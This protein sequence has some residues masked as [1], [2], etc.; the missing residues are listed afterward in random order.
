MNSITEIQRAT[1][2][3]YGLTRDELLGRDRRRR[4]SR[5]RQVA[6]ALS[7]ELTNHSYLRIARNFGRDHSTV[8]HAI[9]K[10]AERAGR[11]ELRKMNAVRAKLL[12][13]GGLRL[14]ARREQQA[15]IVLERLA[16]F[17]RE[18]PAPMREAA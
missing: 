11:R 2:A 15:A 7:R 17:V 3:E 8:I 13:D 12:A 6:M 1:A 5:P 10:V 16:A 18:R 4:Y 14:R 9:Q